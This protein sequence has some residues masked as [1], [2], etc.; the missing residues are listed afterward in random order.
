MSYRAGERF[1]AHLVRAATFVRRRWRGGLDPDEVYAYLHMVA[2]EMEQLQR[3]ATTA[4]TEAE[5]IREGLRQ[6]RSRHVG[7]R[8]VDPPT[9]C[10]KQSPRPRSGSRSADDSEPDQPPRNGGH[11]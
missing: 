6:W 11:W 3:E 4:R 5:R 9:W 1:G 10:V 7:C 8:F 2:D